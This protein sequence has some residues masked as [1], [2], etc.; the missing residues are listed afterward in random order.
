M[1]RSLVYALVAFIATAVLIYVA[2]QSSPWQPQGE[3]SEPRGTGGGVGAV[4]VV[5]VPAT[6]VESGG[7]LGG[8]RAVIVEG[9]IEPSVRSTLEELTRRSSGVTV[10][11]ETVALPLARQSGIVA[12]GEAG[13]PAKLYTGTGV[14]VEGVDELDRVKVV[15]GVLYAARRGVVYRVDLTVMKPLEPINATRVADELWGVVNITLRLPSGEVVEETVK[16]GVDLRG[17][18]YLG[19]GYLAFIVSLRYPLFLPGV[20]SWT[21]VLVYRGGELTCAS[22][23]RGSLI[24]ARGAEGVLWLLLSKQD[25]PVITPLGAR[26][27]I[28]KPGLTVIALNASTCRGSRV[29]LGGYPS[30]WRPPLLLVVNSTRAY[31]VASDWKETIV[32]LL[33]YRGGRLIAERAAS[34]EGALPRNWLALSMRNDTLLLVLEG[35]KGGF[36]LYTLNASTLDVLARLVVERRWER[37]YAIRLLGNY[38]YV[39]T[40]RMVDPLFVINVTDPLH[41]RVLGWRKGPGFDALL[42]PLNQS[43]IVGLGFT[44]D[45]ALRL[46]LYRVEPD[47]SLSLLDERVF[48]GIWAPRLLAPDAYRYLMLAYSVVGYPVSARGSEEVLLVKHDGSGF[49]GYTL[50]AGSRSVAWRGHIYVVGAERVARI[51]PASLYVEAIAPLSP[52]G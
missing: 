50:V 51:N 49:D 3:A 30:W 28:V 1:E 20:S 21:G 44:D 42:A 39:V 46:R 25:G 19:D 11:V 16:S 22:L 34:L 23:E 41:P 8:R 10:T 47:A 7:P 14:A 9:V 12:S 24:D 26:P 37:V 27:G 36:I 2:A 17:M 40:Y 31:L 4:G 33:E 13:G 6:S 52:S 43:L 32:A 35:K 48:R 18:V 5:N 45:R 38:L 15:E 29:E